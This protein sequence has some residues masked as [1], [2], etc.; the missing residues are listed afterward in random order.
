MLTIMERNQMLTRHFQSGTLPL[1]IEIAANS[2]S[3]VAVS[4]WG[5]SPFIGTVGKW[6]DWERVFI[7]TV[8]SWWVMNCFD[9]P[10]TRE[11][12]FRRGLECHG[13]IDAQRVALIGSKD[14]SVTVKGR[15]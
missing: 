12:V 5:V 1:F 10:A 11:V 2:C 9:S 3:K 4:D 8:E 14:E 7:A 13:T 15:T 6:S